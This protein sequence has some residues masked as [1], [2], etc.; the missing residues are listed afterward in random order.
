MEP[1]PNGQPVPVTAA[2]AA[3]KAQQAQQKQAADAQNA[4]TDKMLSLQAQIATLQEETKR[5][6]N[7][8]DAINDTQETI[9]KGLDSLRDFIAQ[10]TKTEA[11]YGV[12]VPGGTVTGDEEL[13]PVVTQ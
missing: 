3:Q 8:A 12:D 2:E 9:Q 1:G 11:E 10:Q 13:G 7:T 5:Q 6:K 4:Q